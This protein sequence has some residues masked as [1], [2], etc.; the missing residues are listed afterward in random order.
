[1]G[2]VSSTHFSSRLFQG[3]LDPG[4]RR[5]DDQKDFLR[6]RQSCLNSKSKKVSEASYARSLKSFGNEPMRHVAA[7]RSGALNLKV[8]GCP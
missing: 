8:E 1:V 2:K 4:I 3:V 7:P 5:G 6:S